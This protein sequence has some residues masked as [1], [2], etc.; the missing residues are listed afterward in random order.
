MIRGL[1]VILM[2]LL[3]CIPISP[4]RAQVTLDVAKITCDQFSG[5]KI[6]NPQKYCDLAERL[7]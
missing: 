4:V 7:P 5:Y 6:T 1:G 3:T 2:L